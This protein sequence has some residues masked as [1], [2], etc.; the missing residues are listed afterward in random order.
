MEDLRAIINNVELP[1]ELPSNAFVQYQNKP[2]LVDFWVMINNLPAEIRQAVDRDST[3]S[4]LSPEKFSLP[5]KTGQYVSVTL[6]DYSIVKLK[7]KES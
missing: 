5:L 3:I 1:I 2:R 4:T 7:L 6:K